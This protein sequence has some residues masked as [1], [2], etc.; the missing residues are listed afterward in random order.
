MVRNTGV[1][2]AFLAIASKLIDGRIRGPS[3]SFPGWTVTR[4]CDSISFEDFLKFKWEC[5]LF[6]VFF[7]REYDQKGEKEKKFFF[8]DLSLRCFFSVENQNRQDRGRF[9]LYK[10]IFPPPILFF[11]KYFSF[12]SDTLFQDSIFNFPKMKN[13]SYPIFNCS[14]RTVSLTLNHQCQQFLKAEFGK[15]IPWGRS[16]LRPWFKP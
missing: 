6:M 9:L 13:F 5:F 12:P 11:P 15:T 14:K 10:T 7:R 4:S 8:S 16:G 3:L 1:F 2:K